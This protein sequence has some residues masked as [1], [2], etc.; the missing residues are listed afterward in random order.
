MNKDSHTVLL[1]AK[2]GEFVDCCYWGSYYLAKNTG[3]FKQCGINKNSICFMRS[4]FKPVQ[5]TLLFDYPEIIKK[6]SIDSKEIAIFSGS[7]AGSPEH[8]KILKNILKKTGLNEK[9]LDI[10]PIEPLDKR[11]FNGNF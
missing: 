10:A 3:I 11:R 8:I 2:R 1:S 9:N 4:L 6:Y 7:H 5:A